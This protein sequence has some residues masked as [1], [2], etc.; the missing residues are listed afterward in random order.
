MAVPSPREIPSIPPKVPDLGGPSHFG[1]QVEARFETQP[2]TGEFQNI[3]QVARIA[4]Q[5]GFD[6]PVPPEVLEPFLKPISLTP[7]SVVRGE[8]LL[9][10]ASP[11]P[12]RFF[13]VL[14][15]AGFIGGYFNAVWDLIGAS[16]GVE[17]QPEGDAWDHTMQVL[18]RARK[19]D[20]NCSKGEM[21]AV[22]GLYF[23]MAYQARNVPFTGYSPITDFC[24]RLGLR[25][26]KEMWAVADHRTDLHNFNHLTAESRLDLYRAARGSY[27]IGVEGFAKVCQADA[28]GNCQ[29]LA[30]NP[31][32]QRNA[33]LEM[34]AAIKA[35]DISS[36]KGDRD[37]IRAV[38]IQAILTFMERTRCGVDPQ[39]RTPNE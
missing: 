10:L 11:S 33:F 18:D 13:H 30:L 19:P 14:R 36:L 25:Y 28:Q 37:G 15:V 6:W 17:Y 2:T 27:R 5:H 32:P 21:M 22:L 8:I 9:A 35:T 16:R 31:Y 23:N 4:A 1:D 26:E 7:P 3:Y 12:S 39:E 34:V 29:D 20:L 38:Q 24:G